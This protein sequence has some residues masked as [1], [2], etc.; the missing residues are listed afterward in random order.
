M[1]TQ[2]GGIAATLCA[3]AGTVLLALMLA[4]AF[5]LYP[6]PAETSPGGHGPES[7][8]QQGVSLAAD[9]KFEEAI[10][11]W[12]GIEPEALPPD[13]QDLRSYYLGVAYE[14]AGQR[15]EAWYW[16]QLHLTK[17][18][19]PQEDAAEHLAQVE[20]AMNEDGLVRATV[21]CAPNGARATPREGGLAYPCP[22]TWW[23]TKGGHDVSVEKEGCVPGKVRV[24][25]AG[26]SQAPV[27]FALDCPAVKAPGEGR[28][29][30]DVWKWVVL[31]SGLAIVA[32]GGILHGVASARNDNLH[33]KYPPDPGNPGNL[34]SYNKA[35]D[36]EVVPMRTA[37]YVMYGV[38]GAAAATGAVLL[39]L[40]LDKSEEKTTAWRITPQALP[41]GA[42]VTLEWRFQL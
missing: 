13:L 39:L 4:V 2:K 23:Y 17:A 36:R 24:V 41:G 25:A 34:D 18:G 26:K 14:N 32:T 8:F 27:P 42:T 21:N 1:N 31:G 30:S 28:K 38:G 9:G 6:S 12:L 33:D 16:L 37:S 15:P 22:L 11:V 35:F 5:S 19:T 29:P 20:K 40:D 3:P 10:D 7:L